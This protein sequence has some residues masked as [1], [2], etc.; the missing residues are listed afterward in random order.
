[1]V[2]EIVAETSHLLLITVASYLSFLE[3]DS[4]WK[5]GVLP[6]TTLH[7]LLSVCI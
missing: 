1:M 5:Q 6:Q 7:L 2:P 3:V 4:T